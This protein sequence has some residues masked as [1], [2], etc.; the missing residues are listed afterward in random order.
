MSPVGE[1]SGGPDQF[2][3]DRARPRARSHAST[4]KPAISDRN[5]QLHAWIR[6]AGPSNCRTEF[7]RTRATTRPTKPAGGSGESRRGAPSPFVRTRQPFREG[8]QPTIRWMIGPDDSTRS[9][10]SPSRSPARATGTRRTRSPSRRM[11][12]MLFPRTGIS[13]DAPS[14]KSS[15]TSGAKRSGRKRSS[16]ETSRRMAPRIPEAV[17]RVKV[18]PEPC[19]RL[20]G[21]RRLRYAAVGYRCSAR[22]VR[23]AASPRPGKE[24]R[25]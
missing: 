15:R 12:R 14:A 24:V 5:A 20:T 22:P 6:I 4:T 19:F 18:E 23:P 9:T 7:P 17:R 1:T 25:S 10:M 2:P 21:T 11:G 8:H 3:L 16:K 13:G